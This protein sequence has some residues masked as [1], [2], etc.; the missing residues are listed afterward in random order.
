VP[1]ELRGQRVVAFAVVRDDA[2]T[3]DVRA[4]ALHNVG[5]S[6]APSLHLVPSL[7]KTKNGKIMRRAIRARHL[8]EPAGDMS[9]LEPTTP[10]EDIPTIEEA[11][12]R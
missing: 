11:G 7:P 2:D 5:R 6:F 1:D 3:E 9:A 10:L 8:G 4:Q 12:N